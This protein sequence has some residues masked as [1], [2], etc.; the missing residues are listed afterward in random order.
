MPGTPATYTSYC[1]PSSP[2][3]SAS[4]Q[5]GQAA[6]MD[7]ELSGNAA[8]NN[9]SSSNDSFDNTKPKAYLS[10]RTKQLSGSGSPHV[11][12]HASIVA[13]AVEQLTQSQNNSMTD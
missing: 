6:R 7:M 12:D 1:D 10:Q 5:A 11:A 2:A 9:S 3:V 13:H 4:G 8:G